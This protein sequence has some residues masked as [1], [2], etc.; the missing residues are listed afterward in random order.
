MTAPAH[1]GWVMG[2][3]IALLAEALG[4][5]AACSIDSFVASSTS[6]GLAI[7]AGAIG[8]GCALRRARRRTKRPCH[9]PD[10]ASSARGVE[11]WGAPRLTPLPSGRIVVVLPLRAPAPAAWTQFF[12][13]ATPRPPYC[14]PALVQIDRAGLGFIALEEHVGLWLRCVDDWIEETNRR[15][16]DY[17]AREADRNRTIRTLL[18]CPDATLRRLASEIWPYV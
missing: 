1:S 5:L 7:S 4:I 10:A 12:A 17:E 13:Y 8:L 16:R 9:E 15:Y 14:Y 18:L 6:V 2:V 3:S 11:R